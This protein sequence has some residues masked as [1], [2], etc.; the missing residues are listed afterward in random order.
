M[1]LY[2]KKKYCEQY[3]IY[4]KNISNVIFIPM[5]AL[6]LFCWRENND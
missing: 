6:S 2:L 4:E 1:V 5:P 3:N